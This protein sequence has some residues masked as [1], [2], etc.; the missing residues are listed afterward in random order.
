MEILN[1]VFTINNINYEKILIAFCFMSFVN[2][3][4]SYLEI[5]DEADN[6]EWQ[7]YLFILQCK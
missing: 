3:N 1:C 4:N 7:I 6:T 2:Y 5:T